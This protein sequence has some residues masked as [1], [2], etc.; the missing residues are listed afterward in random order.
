M[1]PVSKMCV[2]QLLY[3]KNTE[4]YAAVKNDKL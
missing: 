1:Q 2:K 3:I 4:K